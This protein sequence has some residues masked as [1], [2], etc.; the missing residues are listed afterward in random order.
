MGGAAGYIPLA[1]QAMRPPA[2][3]GAGTTALPAKPG[4]ATQGNRMNIATTARAKRAFTLIELLVVIAIIA[5]LAAVLFPTLAAAKRSA[6]QAQ[7]QSNLKQLGF[8]IHAYA[9]DWDD[10]FPYGIDFSDAYNVDIYNQSRVVWLV[11]DAED[12]VRAL[13]RVP[14]RGGY[15]DGVLRPY[16]RTPY[17]WRCPSDIGM[18][19]QYVNQ[20]YGGRDTGGETVFDAFGMSYTYRTELGL[21]GYTIGGLKHPSE[22]N[23]LQDAAGYWHT[24][25]SRGTRPTQESDTSDAAKWS[26]NVLF[27]DGHV[28]NTTQVDVDKSYDFDRPEDQGP[29]EQQTLN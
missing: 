5:I 3:W 2:A 18:T 24:R 16:T 21:A 6:Y 29:Q 7:C 20:V 23:V 15:I 17:L 11:P 19:F 28:K 26:Y 12:R 1:R 8:A 10:T 13:M 4:R 9:Q 25:Y 22:V 14:N 27:A